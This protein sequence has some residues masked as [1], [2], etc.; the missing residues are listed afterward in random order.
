V[1]EEPRFF[2]REDYDPTGSV[3]KALEQ[4]SASQVGS[5]HPPAPEPRR[6]LAPQTAKPARAGWLPIL[7]ADPGASLAPQPGLPHWNFWF[8]VFYRRRD[9][10]G[11]SPARKIPGEA[12]R[13]RPE[14]PRR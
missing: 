9:P 10:P 13:A 7:S 14:Y 12:R 11:C 5:R 4:C 1:V 8:L 2:L 6:C 3:R